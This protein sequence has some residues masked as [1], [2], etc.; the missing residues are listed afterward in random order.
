M[1]ALSE[2]TPRPESGPYTRSISSRVASPNTRPP[3]RRDSSSPAVSLLRR[4]LARAS[5]EP[6]CWSTLPCWWSRDR[7]LVHVVDVYHRAYL[8]TRHE[9]V[10]TTGGGVSLRA[11][12]AVATAH[13]QAADFR[14][15][16]S[17]RPLLGTTRG[18]V[19]L[20]AATGLGQRTVTRART[21][22]RLVGL[23]TEVQ[24]GRH[25]SF[26]E[27]IASWERGDK[28]RGWTAEYALHPSEKY[29]DPVDN[30]GRVIAGQMVCG[31][32]PP[33][34]SLSTGRSDGEV[35]TSTAAKPKDPAARDED[36]A[37][38]H[39]STTA[40]TRDGSDASRSTG[41]ALMLAWRASE[42]CPRWARRYG[43]HRWSGALT[44]ATAAGW[45]A[46]DLG[47]LLV[48]LAAT[49][50]PVLRDPRRP[51]SYLCHLL[52][53]VDL[54]ER[55]TAL[56]DAQ[57]AEDIAHRQTRTAAQLD[58]RDADAAAREVAVAALTGSGRTAALAATAAAAAAAARRRSDQVS[59][60]RLALA[61]RVTRRRSHR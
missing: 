6:I 21:W 10:A 42:T 41:T 61:E 37:P 7:W 31:T 16:R 15:G 5:V 58:R 8:L 22:L 28:G 52:G 32:P 20:T 53:L 11:V 12:T 48:D 1:R 25:R 36:G 34:G 38:R 40:G 43:A 33:G 9:L 17:S 55:P 2:G 18:P 57:A 27:R 44:A 47:Q 24:G 30:S 26:V 45:T 3:V 23:A 39:A 29:P 35:V 56:I 51:V 46:R 14:T 60:E 49:G 59:A 19:G 50:H 54:A 4:P 13:A